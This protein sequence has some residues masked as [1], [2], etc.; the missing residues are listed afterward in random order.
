MERVCAVQAIKVGGRPAAAVSKMKSG[1]LALALPRGRHVVT[2]EGR[3]LNRRLELNFGHVAR[4]LSVQ[5]AGF[6]VQGLAKGRTEGGAL[7]LIRSEGAASVHKGPELTPDPIPPFV[8]VFRTL[9]LDQ[10][11]ALETCFPSSI[12]SLPAF[13]WRRVR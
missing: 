3:I 9:V 11:W 8:R 5:A 12:R 13:R 4:N 10:E 7:V 1:L 2:L 6:S